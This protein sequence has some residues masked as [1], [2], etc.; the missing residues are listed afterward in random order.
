VE[1]IA[2]CIQEEE[3]IVD[4][5]VVSTFHMCMLEKDDEDEYLASSMQAYPVVLM[6]DFTL[7]EED[8]IE[9]NLATTYKQGSPRKVHT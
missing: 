6:I 1:E 7:E 8:V 3:I 2:A 5:W 4:L 9:E